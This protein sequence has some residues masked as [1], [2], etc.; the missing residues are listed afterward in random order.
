[1]ETGVRR[2]SSLRAAKPRKSRAFPGEA[3]KCRFRESGWW[4]QTESNCEP[5]S[6]WI[7]R[8]WQ[9]ADEFDGSRPALEKLG[10]EAAR[11]YSIL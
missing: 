6:R 1:L 10:E 11:A 8:F 3:Q 4:S 7:R 2:K 9:I 5:L